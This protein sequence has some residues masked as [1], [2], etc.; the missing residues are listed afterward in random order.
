MVRGSVKGCKW[1]SGVRACALVSEHLTMWMITSAYHN[2]SNNILQVK[3]RRLLYP[4]T[5]PFPKD[6]VTLPSIHLMLQHL[7][8]LNFGEGFPA[9]SYQFI[10]A[11][12][13]VFVVVGFSVLVFKVLVAKKILLLLTGSY[14]ERDVTPAI[15]EDDEL[16]LDLE[17]LLSFSYQVA[18][19]MAFLASKNVSGGDSHGGDFR[20]IPLPTPTAPKEHFRAVVRKQS[21]ICSVVTKS[22]GNR[23]SSCSN[24]CLFGILVLIYKP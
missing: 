10:A 8:V 3:S 19:G 21:A 17:D 7:C 11:A 23:V 6:F 5:F 16:A 13:V 14:I 24:C 15:M 20:K 4:S 22:R 12:V 9:S 2:L 1:L 18:K